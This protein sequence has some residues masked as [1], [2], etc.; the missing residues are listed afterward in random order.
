MEKNYEGLKVLDFTR[1]LAGPYLTMLLADNGAEVIKLERPFTGADEREL[2]PRLEGLH[3]VQSGYFMMLNRGKKSVA[4][5]LKD[6]A[7]RPAVERLLRWADV[8]CENFAPGVMDR[9]GYG[10]EAVRAR[11]PGVVYCSIS[12]FGQE[13]PLSGLP[14]YD[15]LAQAMSG[16]MWITGDPDGPPGRSG[17]A[18]GDVNAATHALGAIGAALYYRSRTGRGQHIDLSLRDCLSAILETA[19]VRCT[20]TGGRE[21]PMRSGPH[22][23]T[24][25]PYGVFRGSKGGYVAIS[26]LLEKHWRGLC[27]AMGREAWGAQPRFGDGTLRSRYAHEIIPAVEDWLG[28]FPDVHAAVEE[29]RR[30]CVP[31][32][33]VLTI[34]ELLAD[35]QYRMRDN[36]VTVDDPVFGPVELPA[37]PMRFSR[38]SVY[39]PAPPPRL[40]E[41]TEQV[42]RDIALLPEAEIQDIL[43]RYQTK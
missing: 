1:V 19:I 9:L 18:I 8:V 4:L 24:L 12:T 3:G 13:G 11:S 38:A 34:P 39:N 26:A 6:P 32:A 36:L 30:H 29:L 5:D 31:A 17:T 7:C 10:Y 40:G 25:T 16:L 28:R 37:T 33:P 20:M 21:S 22:N 43:Q 15:I 14:G 41:H 42:L 23:S 27:A 2:G 35:G